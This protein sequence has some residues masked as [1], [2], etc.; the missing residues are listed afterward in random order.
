LEYKREKYLI[1]LFTALLLLFCIIPLF[2]EELSIRE[3]MVHTLTEKG[4]HPGVVIFIVSMLPIF[5]LRGGI[6][7]GINFYGMPW[8]SV[9]PI[10]IAGNMVPVFPILLLLSPLSRLL[11]RIPVFRRFFNWLFSRTRSRSA[12]VER[13]KAIGLMLFVAI[14]F[15]VTGAWTG[16]VAAFIFNI[17][18]HNAIVS[19]LFGVFIAA[20]IVTILSLLGIWG[21]VIA[22]IA[23]MV[24][25]ILSLR[26]SV[27]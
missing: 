14:P 3:R 22:G 23:L 15:P 8:Y 5:E 13:Y 17:K 2:A 27:K 4:W 11:S 16:S 19:I 18:F 6:P 20:V 7:L 25:G 1:L 26:R 12:V 24:L 10:A 21:A 9:V